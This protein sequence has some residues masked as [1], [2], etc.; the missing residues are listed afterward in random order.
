MKI[1]FKNDGRYSQD[2]MYVP[3]KI[4]DK[5]IGMISKINSDEVECDIFD[6]CITHEILSEDQLLCGIVLQNLI[7]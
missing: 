6:G 7:K 2:E 4:G 1:Y 3:I 5:P